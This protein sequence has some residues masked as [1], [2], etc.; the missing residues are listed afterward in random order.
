MKS[1]GSQ[2]ENPPLE[3]VNGWYVI[4]YG[5]EPV[6]DTEGVFTFV[7]HR[8]KSK[9][10]IERIFFTLE[11]IELFWLSENLLNVKKFLL[12]I[13]EK[14]VPWKESVQTQ[15]AWSIRY[16]N[17]SGAIPKFSSFC[18]SKIFIWFFSARFSIQILYEASQS[19][20][21]YVRIYGEFFNLLLGSFSIYFPP[22][23]TLILYR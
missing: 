4:R 2:V 15:A 14:I 17:S 22:F 10:T 13:I 21:K 20:R 5:Y 6:S 16:R 12:Y 11:F 19:P 9:P 8:F 18:N 23:F 7:E 3:C 1:L